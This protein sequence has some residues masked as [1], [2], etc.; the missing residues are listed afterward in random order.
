[1]TDQTSKDTLVATLAPAPQPLEPEWSRQT[2][3]RILSEDR[4][5]SRRRRSRR[6]VVAGVV[7]GALTASTAAAVAGGGPEDVVKQVLT[8]FTEQ[9]NTSGNDI[10]ELHDP[11]LVAEFETRTGLFAFW[12]ATSSKGGVC[13]AMSDGAWDGQGTPTEDQL[14]MY[15]CGGEIWVGPGDRSEE[16]TR[17]DQVGG[18]FKDTEPM[19]YGVS[20]YADAVAVRVEAPG[21][22]RTLPVRSDSHGYGD[23]LPGADAARAVTLTFLDAGGDV[24]GTKRLVAPVG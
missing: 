4:A 20:P 1:M 5:T 7:A 19:V 11:Q 23:T 21:V 9:P 13:V 15:G 14:G 22:D 8:R 3:Q 17:P 10:G 12:V 18:F 24:L 16:L 2:L 6:L